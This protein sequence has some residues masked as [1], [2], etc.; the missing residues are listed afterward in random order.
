MCTNAHSVCSYTAE[1]LGMW[2]I[3][4][5]LQ[6]TVQLLH[7]SELEPSLPM[8]S[9]NWQKTVNL[10]LQLRKSCYIPRCFR[11]TVRA[12]SNHNVYAGELRMLQCIIVAHK[13]IVDNGYNYIDVIVIAQNV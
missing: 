6:C 3:S 2:N 13:G 12:F 4:D 8:V 11:H 5:G 7:M 9:I 1:L 10:A